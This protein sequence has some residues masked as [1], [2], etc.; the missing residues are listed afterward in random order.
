MGAGRAKALGGAL[1]RWPGGAVTGA[2]RHACAAQGQTRDVHCPPSFPAA[3]PAMPPTR[4][5]G[6]ATESAA[7]TARAFPPPS[8]HCHSPSRPLA[9]PL[10]HDNTHPGGSSL[11][12]RP[13]APARP[14]P[15]LAL[16]W[17]QAQAGPSRPSCSRTTAQSSVRNSCVFTRAQF[18]EKTRPPMWRGLGCWAAPGWSQGS[19]PSRQEETTGYLMRSYRKLFFFFF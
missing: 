19:R 12:R 17:W 11:Q 15:P 3:P 1:L 16:S 8:H 6:A 18:T 5:G 14:G 10:R 2:S 13:P 4:S 9:V 7:A